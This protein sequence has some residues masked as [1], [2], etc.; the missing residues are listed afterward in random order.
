M[1]RLSA[2]AD[3][4]GASVS[5]QIEALKRNRISLIELR[6]ADGINVWEWTEEFALKIAERLSAERI[7]VWA[8][9]SPIG[10]VPVNV[11]MKEYLKGCERIFRIA[12][13]TGTTRVRA[14]SFFGAY[15][16]PR[17][18]AYNLGEIV[19]AA[20]DYGV[21]IYH[22]NEKEIFGDVADRVEYLLD[23]VKGLK[24]V[25]D[26]ANYVQCGEN[27]EKAFKTLAPRT[28][29]YHIKDVVADTGEIVPAGFGD[30]YI[31]G[32]IA[33]AGDNKTFTV[34]PHLKVFDGFGKLESGK[35]KGRFEFANCTESFDCAVGSLKKRLVAAGY[36]EHSDGDFYVGK[37]DN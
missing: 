28:D 27:V 34:E 10:K 37:V 31:D 9:G 26:P 11:D 22:E 1:I 30:G 6:N 23:N 20:S 32:I 7:K 8:I 4:A 5:E 29:Y 25:F 24:S 12:N 2:F 35:L 3:E 13:V 15:D 16:Q 33:N 17:K 18:A 14:F 19:N 36:A 21:E